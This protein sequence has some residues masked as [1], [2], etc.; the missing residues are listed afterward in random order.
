M[1]CGGESMQELHKC[2]G[3]AHV[4]C[5]LQQIV[6]EL[7]VDPFLF[8]LCRQGSRMKYKSATNQVPLQPPGMARDKYILVQTRIF[9]SQVVNLPKCR[10]IFSQPLVCSKTDVV[11]LRLSIPSSFLLFF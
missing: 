2:S 4:P 6:H 9:S 1:N 5:K 8:L 11:S 7:K 10:D 3:L